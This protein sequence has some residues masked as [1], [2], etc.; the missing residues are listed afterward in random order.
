MK[1]E[2]RFKTEQNYFEDFKKDTTD[3]NNLLYAKYIVNIEINNIHEMLGKEDYNFVHLPENLRNKNGAEGF[4]Y[5]YMTIKNIMDGIDDK[6]EPDNPEF[7]AL[8]GS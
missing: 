1:I 7:L 4:L 8:F 6:V 5:A 2:D 3:M